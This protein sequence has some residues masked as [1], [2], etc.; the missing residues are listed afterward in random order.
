MRRKF[1]PSLACWFTYRIF[2]LFH[3]LH[4]SL[5]QELGLGGEPGNKTRPL[6]TVLKAGGKGAS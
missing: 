6:L 5:L 1:I 2:H 3:K 4:Q